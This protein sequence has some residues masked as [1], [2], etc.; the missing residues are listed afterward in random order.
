M[1]LQFDSKLEYQNQ[2]ISSVVDLF[3]GQS[4]MQSL[5]SVGYYDQIAGQIGMFGTDNGI[6]N[7]L[8]L[9]NEEILENLKEIQLRNG[10]Q[11]NKSLKSLDFDIEMETG[12]GKTY[13]Y[14]RTILELHKNYGFTK[15]VIV[16]PGLAIKEGVFKSLNITKEHFRKKQM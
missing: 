12:T 10:L 2:A 14:L 13:V 3:K 4:P 16:V 1:K 11:Q 9:D 5:F 6:G 8:E 7:R 15:F